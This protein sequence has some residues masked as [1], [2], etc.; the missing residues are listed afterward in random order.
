MIVLTGGAGFIGSCFLEKLNSEGIKDILVVDHLDGTEKW[1]N[2]VGKKYL[3]Y[4]QKNDFLELVEE[5]EMPRPAAV[6]HMGACSSTTCTDAE[7]FI[8]NNY[9]YSKAIAEWA[10]SEKVPFLYAS[11][12]A[13]YGAGEQGY[14]D[15]EKKIYDLKPLNMYGYSK[16]MFD[17]WLVNNRL[18]N[19]VTGFKFFNV[20]GPNEYHKG[21]MMSVVCKKYSEIKNENKIR[22][23]KSYDKNYP[24]GGQKR[25]FIYVKDAVEIMYY[26]FKK[27]SKTGIFNVGTGEAKTWNEL[28]EAMF[29]AAGKKPAIEY[30]DMPE[31]LRSKYQNF[32]QADMAKLKKAGCRHKFMTLEDAVQDYVTNYLEDKNYL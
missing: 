30:I 8:K 20:Y 22:L 16:H 9:E 1:K 18:V 15:E 26:F 17:L 32:T 14:S 19:K 4:I 21:D 27:P 24:D 29:K 13:T 28:A 7:Y 3:D 10:L 5:G 6:V 12:A 25:D 23:F 11:S 31:Q 2:L